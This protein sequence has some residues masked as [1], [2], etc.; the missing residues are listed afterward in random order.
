[1]GLCPIPRKPFLKKGLDP[2]NFIMGNFEK[3]NFIRR[4][5]FKVFGILKTLFQ[6]GFK[7]G[8]GKSPKSSRKRGFGAKPQELPYS[9]GKNMLIKA[10][11]LA[12]AYDETPVATDIHFSVDAGDY[13]CIVG[14]N[15]SGKSTLVKAIV[16]LHPIAAG[17]LTID[18]EVRR[19]GIGYLPQHTPAQRD[20][21]A[22]VREIVRSGCLRRAGM[23]PLWRSSDKKLADE[24]MERMG[25]AH[26]ASRCYR[27]LSGGQQQRVLLA[28][29]FCATG[30]L[31]VLDEPIA[32]LDPF[33]MTE[34]YRMIADLN[35]E[36]VAVVM[37]SHDVSAAVN[38]A[39]HILHISKTT[40]FYGSTEG[41]LKTPVGQQFSRLSGTHGDWNPSSAWDAPVKPDIT[42]V[43]KKRRGKGDM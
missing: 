21:P 1:M 9:K 12:L 39:D 23:N 17:T 43:L 20:F 30:K 10:E 37:V 18:P 27:E 31:I 28:R 15:G 16:G 36:G 3:S 22:S 41:Y 42:D 2:K 32:G 6:K 4:T 40:N 29:A 7:R 24:A 35:R 8:L 26:L 34:M 33:A 25:I 11:N 13:L 5:I 38:F 14:E 19:G